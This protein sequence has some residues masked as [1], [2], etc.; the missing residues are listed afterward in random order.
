[1]RKLLQTLIQKR[2]G[3]AVSGGRSQVMVR[4]RVIFCELQSKILHILE[5]GLRVRVLKPPPQGSGSKL[6]LWKRQ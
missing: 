6:S 4:V 5:E 1:M 2:L 3:V